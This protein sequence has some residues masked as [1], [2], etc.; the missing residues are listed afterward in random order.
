[1]L[2]LT[3][4]DSR[5]RTS[6][7]FPLNKAAAELSVV[8]FHLELPAIRPAL[9][10][11]F[12]GHLA[13]STRNHT[14]NH[15]VGQRSILPHRYCTR[16]RS[17]SYPPICSTTFRFLQ[18]TCLVRV[19]RRHALR[20]LARRLAFARPPARSITSPRLVFLLTVFV[21]DLISTDHHFHGSRLP[22]LH[23]EL[24]RRRSIAF[25]EDIAPCRA[26]SRPTFRPTA[27]FQRRSST[28]SLVIRTVSPDGASL[29]DHRLP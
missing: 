28:T 29:R 10:D 3:M 8:A 19:R 7:C 11:V 6:S 25:P 14:R 18:Q 22:P 1:M 4:W 20:N 12:D 26:C 13:T 2:I 5:R 16:P 15:G 23:G 27:F 21:I 9:I 17:R 24:A